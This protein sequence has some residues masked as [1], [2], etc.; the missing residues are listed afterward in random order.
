MPLSADRYYP[1]VMVPKLQE[2]AEEFRI[3]LDS[4]PQ[5]ALA[6]LWRLSNAA[7]GYCT[8][9]PSLINKQLAVC[10]S[11][12]LSRGAQLSLEEGGS[13]KVRPSWYALR[14][15]GEHAGS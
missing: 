8:W 15:T 4:G 13:R 6:V 2:A 10:E 12:I 3:C 7:G 11:E 1:T 5:G 14:A 9:E